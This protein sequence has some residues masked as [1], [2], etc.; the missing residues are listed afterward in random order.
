[1]TRTPTSGWRPTRRPRL[2]ISIIGLVA[3]LS[4]AAGCAGS[5]T[6]ASE[7][8]T[9]PET[10]IIKTDEGDVEIPAEVEKIVT[11]HNIATQPLIDL[12]VTPVGI[13]PMD[14]QTSYPE[15]WEKIKDIKQIGNSGGA[16]N[17]EMV[18]ELAPDLIFA[19]NMTDDQ[20]IAK[21]EQIAPVIQIGIDGPKR[22]QW[23]ERAELVAE[24]VQK[25]DEA[26]QLEKQYE[27][28]AAEIK[29][30]YGDVLADQTVNVLDSF[31]KSVIS[32][33]SSTSMVGNILVLAGGRFAPS[34]ESERVKAG[35]GSSAG[36]SREEPFS[37]E[38][39]AELTDGSVILHGSQV[40]QG[41]A[42][43]PTQQAMLDS[44]LFK[45]SKA[46]KAGH[47]YPIGKTTIAGYGDAFGTLDLFESALKQL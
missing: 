33:Y 6:A 37:Y 31:D 10:R 42:P 19:T 20:E 30:T 17:I 11:T 26:K 2:V 14:A 4:L 13:G 39:L 12:G 28:R 46:A 24:V 27:D 34:G 18:A 15:Y 21:L 22:S 25:E 38:E 41:N 23:R 44:S 8:E 35:D 32:P 40:T 5:N 3:A 7:G 36:S 45:A 47:V 16:A 43:T 9:A 1:M 29:S